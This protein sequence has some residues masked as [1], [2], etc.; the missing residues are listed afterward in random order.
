MEKGL[1][2]FAD[3]IDE[4]ARRG[5]KHRV[6]AVGDGPARAWFD[7]RLPRAVFV[8][9]LGGTDLGRAVAS[10]D[11]LFNPSI[12]E[13]FGIVTL[14]AMSCGLPVVGA[15]AAGTSS[16]VV[17]GVTGRLIRPD[18]VGSFADALA[19]Y[20]VDPDQRASAGAAGAH[21]AND[22][23]WDAVNHAL[24]ANYLRVIERRADARVPVTAHEHRSAARSPLAIT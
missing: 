2:V 11:I 15:D 8:G 4:L 23:S 22:Y 20:V 18:A 21:A 13:T 12:T 17:E 10:M 14:E 1:G 9:F 6:L 24:A 5:V 19:A 3:T 16:L 7:K